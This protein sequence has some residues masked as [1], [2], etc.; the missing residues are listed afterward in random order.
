MSLTSLMSSWWLAKTM[1]LDLVATDSSCDRLSWLS[2]MRK[3]P[4]AWWQRAPQVETEGLAREA[5]RLSVD[6]QGDHITVEWALFHR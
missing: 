6:P 3:E 4:T 1:L 5:G 2:A